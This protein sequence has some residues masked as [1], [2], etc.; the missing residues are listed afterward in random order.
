MKTVWKVVSI[1]GI[2]ALTLGV[3]CIVVGFFTG[4]S[5]SRIIDTIFATY[6]MDYYLSLWQ[7]LVANVTG[8]FVDIFIV[9]T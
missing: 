1:I 7:Q 9:Y 2:A 5:V 6:D 8:C 3:I 4:G